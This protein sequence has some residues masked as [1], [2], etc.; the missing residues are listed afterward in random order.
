[1]SAPEHDPELFD[2]LMSAE[3]RRQ[4]VSGYAIATLVVG[5]LGG[6]FAPFLAIVA[7]DRI[8]KRRERGRVLVI[9]GLVAFAGWAGVLGY[10]VANGTAWWQQRPSQD[11]LPEGTVHGLDLTVGDC[12]WSPPA[13]GATDVLRTS[14]TT[15]HTAEAFEVLPVTGGPM[16]DIVEVYQR[17]L[18]RCEADAR[19][20]PDVRVQVVTPTSQSWAEGKHRVVCYYRF[21]TEMTEPAR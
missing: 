7:L 10:Q 16:P 6:L 20:L 8:R 17:T 3:L 5:L 11:R 19:P 15:P 2:E 1:M 13:S 4:P 12:F 18:A 9:C 14:C 21:A